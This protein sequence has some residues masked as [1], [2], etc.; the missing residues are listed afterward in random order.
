[1]PLS[2]GRIAELLREAGLPDGVLQIVHGGKETVE[3]ICDHPGIEAISFVGSTKV[4]KI[5]YRRGT[6]EPQARARARRREESPHRHARR[7]SGDDVG[8]RR[9]VDVGLRRPAL[10][11][12]V[13]DDGGR[14]KTD[15]II[16]RMVDIAQAMVPGKDIGPVISAEA[17]AA[18]RGATSP[19]RRQRARRCWSTAADTTVPGRESGYYVGPTLIDHVTPDMRIAQEEVFGPVMVI[20]RAKDVDEALGVRE[21]LAV[22]QRRVACSPR[23]AAWRAT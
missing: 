15:H 2:A 9:R 13:G 14:R 8:E 23:A 16:E 1:M 11:G 7:R 19:R 6:V 5:V 12:G 3:A 20:I 10:H 22:R 21:R 18:H 4:A 17:K